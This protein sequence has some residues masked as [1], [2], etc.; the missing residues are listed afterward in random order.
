[1]TWSKLGSL[2]LIWAN[3]V[4]VARFNLV[5]FKIPAKIDY[6]P[7]SENIHMSP[8]KRPPDTPNP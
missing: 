7:A 8:S 3:V 1:M 4:F 2:S 6:F 5:S